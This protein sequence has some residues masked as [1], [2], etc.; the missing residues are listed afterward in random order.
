LDE[1]AAMERVRGELAQLRFVSEDGSYTVAQLH[2]EG[3]GPVMIRGALG[4]ARV[5]EHVEVEGRWREDRRWGRQLHVIRASVV[6]PI[7]ADGIARYLGGGL[8]DGIGPVLARRL[9]DAF[10]VET[11]R[12]LSEEPERVL[13]V[14]GIGKVRAARITQA[15]REHEGQ[16]QVMAFLHSHA[17]SSAF[18]TRILS[19][20]GH[21]AI[22]KILEDPYELSY[23][24]HGIGFLKADQVA[25]ALGIEADDVRRVKAGVLYVLHESSSDGHMFLLLPELNERAAEL[26]QLKPHAIGGALVE[27]ERARHI[28]I[29]PPAIA[30]GPDAPPRIWSVES[31]FAEREAA[32]HLR[33]LLTTSS[34]RLLLPAEG[35]ITHE[36]ARL[37]VT[38]AA[39]Q[40]RAVREVWTSGVTIL[41][42]GP[43]TGKTTLVRVIVGAAK[44][45]NM[46]V[47]LAAPTGRAARRMSEATGEDAATIHRLLKFQ[48]SAQAFF[49]NEDEPLDADLLIVDESSM[50][51]TAL[52]AALVSACP[53]GCR[54]VFVGD[55][56]QLPSVGPGDVL[57]SLI[58][59]AQIPVARLNEVFRQEGASQIITNA[60]NILRGQLP[61]ALASSE[62]PGDFYWIK[63]EDPKR[64][65]ELIIEV[66]TKRI[67]SAF[68]LDPRHDIQVLCPMRRGEVG[69]DTLNPLLQAALHADA[70]RWRRAPDKLWCVGDRV[71]QTRND[72]TQEVYNGDVGVIEALLPAEQKLYVR[73][74][75]RVVSYGPEQ[76]PDLQLANALTIH[77]SQ[78]SEY[79]A[80]VIPMLTQH[81]MMLRRQLLYTAITRAKRLVILI[82]SPRAVEIAV[83]EARATT[84]HTQLAHRLSQGP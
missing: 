22:K 51:D 56:D 71:I 78:G 26:L 55:A 12:V 61:D 48:P 19:R 35:H 46:R 65:Q 24:I 34:T 23:A 79:P 25:R 18:A 52:L 32:R 69:C 13:S 67:P 16:Q 45:V 10:G 17:L 60:H 54:V 30:E 36:E 83:R 39:A 15:W 31:S 1:Q 49:H 81:F 7:S 40:R 53:D 62:R 8:V 70:P 73:F 41:T 82:G 14:E 42:G 57:T 80:V 75:E 72:Y 4:N 47:A 74:D 29:E 3:R 33:R 66:V 68:G 28:I 43:G 44:A 2:V 58:A 6:P 59:C 84:R 5:G 63:V 11:Q 64:A 27:L 21:E 20:W 76:L 50:I 38:L 9:V 77:K 37:G